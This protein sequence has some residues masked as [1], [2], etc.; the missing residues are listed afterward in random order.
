MGR[1]EEL[2]EMTT[3]MVDV[4]EQYEKQSIDRSTT[5]EKMTTLIE[6]RDEIMNELKPPYTDE[7]M[8]IG[9]KVIELNEQITEKMEHIYKL[10]KEDMSKVKKKKA[11][12]PSYIN[13]YGNLRTTDGLYIDSKK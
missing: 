13:P 9:K 3:E 2:L 6:R 10:V 12:N 4:L 11:Y 5:I 7:E 8:E 1:L